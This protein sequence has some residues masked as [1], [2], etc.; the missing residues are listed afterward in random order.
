[1]LFR[2]GLTVFLLFTS[3]LV[4]A[5]GHF[6]LKNEAKR[7]KIRFQLI[8]NL[9]LIPVTVNG[10]SL[11]FLLD[12]GVSKPILFN[13]EGIEDVLHI[14][15]S[16]RIFL[17]GL[18]GGEPVAALKSSGNK[19]SVGDAYNADLQLYII[20][21]STLNFAPRLGVPVHGIIGYDVFK[22]LVVEI[23]YSNSHI[24]F[25]NQESYVPKNCKKCEVF[26]LEF[27]HNKPYL[28]AAVEMNGEQIPV[29]L[30]IDSGGSDALWLF[31]NDSAGIGLGD[32]NAFQDFLGHGLS[33]SVY[34]KR[35]KV[36][37]FYLK[38][39]SLK[40]ANVAF[41]DSSSVSVSKHIE[42][43]NG[44]VSG[45]I[46]KRFNLVFDYKRATLTLK[47]N[48]FFKEAFKYNYSGI[49]LEHTGLRL[50]TEEVEHGKYDDYTNTA[51]DFAT[52]V[53][54]NKSYRTSVKPAFTIVELRKD[55]PAERA[56]LQLGDVILSVNGRQ[57]HDMQLQKVM[58]MFYDDEGTVIRLRVMRYGVE[59]VFVFE[60]E[61]L[62]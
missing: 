9:I 39:F 40:K 19:V 20:Y 18:G 50:V 13:F 11:T 12:T 60:L 2:T 53:V 14:K 35:S 21:D 15:H 29:K 3:L 25:H 52:R 5:Q 47:K 43:R 54:I 34:G 45:N 4:S 1:M 27:H 31:E 62:L 16:E 6:Y 41:P 38:D 48:R 28:K 26:S 23:N 56:G 33:G 30:L 61:S 55:S 46:L 10:E 44:S 57:T 7:D 51:E 8:N 24:K 49:E 22:D 37:R 58:A 32:N 36:D 42:G 17:R 59:K